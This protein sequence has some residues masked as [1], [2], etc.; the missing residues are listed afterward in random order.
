MGPLNYVMPRLRK[1]AGNHPVLSVKRTA[2]A[3]P[4]TGSPKAHELEEKTL[5]DVAFGL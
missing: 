1:I 5:I 3:S 2:S 4:A